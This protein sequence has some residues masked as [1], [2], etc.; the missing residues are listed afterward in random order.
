MWEESTGDEHGIVDGRPSPETPTRP[1]TLKDT[2]YY[3]SST[4]R[5]ASMTYNHPIP[6]QVGG[7]IHINLGLPPEE[8]YAER[9]RVS[10]KVKNIYQN[11]EKFR[12]AVN[13]P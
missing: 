9:E 2:A 12:V 4:Y 13:G 6:R 7:I 11:L 3:D 8:V 5:S 10:G 1:R